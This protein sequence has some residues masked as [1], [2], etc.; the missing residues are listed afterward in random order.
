[1]TFQDKVRLLRRSQ[2]MNRAWYLE[3]YKDVAA[4]KID[5]VEHYLR[6][7]AALGRDPGPHF[8]TRF[9]K[10]AHASEFS[11]GLNP[12]VHYLTMGRDRQLPCQPPK[13]PPSSPSRLS[14]RIAQLADALLS[15]GFRDRARA[16]LEAAC[17]AGTPLERAA[18]AHVLAAST[19]PDVPVPGLPALP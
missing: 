4:L 1:M 3:T 2:E 12:L 7:G 17:D 14:P 11:E 6:L 10:Q 19:P 18:A 16:D 9:Y 13:V 15:L 8:D 5:P